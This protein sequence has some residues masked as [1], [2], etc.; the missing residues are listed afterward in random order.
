M[1]Q[2]VISCARTLLRVTYEELETDVSVL[3]DDYLGWVRD[4]VDALREAFVELERASTWND[5]AAAESLRQSILATT[6]AISE[7]AGTFGYSLLAEIADSLSAVLVQEAGAR[8]SL[9]E[10]HLSILSKAIALGL[11]GDGGAV[12]ADLITRLPH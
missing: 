4:D 10:A 12:G 8:L 2:I 3:G 1:T 11:K 7:Q 5:E 9:I 6:Q